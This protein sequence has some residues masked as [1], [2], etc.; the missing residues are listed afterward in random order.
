MFPVLNI[1]PAVI[2]T[3][4]LLLLLGFY[5]GLSLAERFARR[6]GQNPDTLTNLV[7]LAG[8]TGLVTAR[9]AFAAEHLG[10]F[11]KNLAGLISFDPSL[12][13]PWGGLAGT[14]IAA[15]IYGQRK[16]LKFWTTLDGL[17]PF[18]AVMAV[19]IGL[20]HV[21]SGQAFGSPTS[22]PWAIELW[23]AKR[24]P[25]QIYE[26]IG[27][28]AILFLLWKQ[29]GSAARNGM[30][31]LKFAGLTSGMAVFLSAFRGDSI[32]ILGAFRQEQLLA[33]ITLGLVF[34]LMEIKS[35]P[36]KQGEKTVL[37]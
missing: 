19:C 31:F 15:L 9:L 13:D 10:L 3:S 33:L 18:L 30:L 29:N 22:L 16:Q 26:T 36:G 20:A 7:L 25:S 28:I 8:L 37:P 4:S 34:L 5:L 12:L 27:A 11:Q 6:G 21:A 32:L 1:G 2:Q 17:T 14:G 24:H 35:I 23:G